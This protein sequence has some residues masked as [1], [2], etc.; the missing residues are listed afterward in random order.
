MFS[1][2]FL[3]L[4]ILACAGALFFGGACAVAA[5]YIVQD[6]GPPQDVKQRVQVIF[7]DATGQAY[8]KTLCVCQRRLT[9]EYLWSQRFSRTKMDICQPAIDFLKD[10]WRR[11]LILRKGY[12]H[13]PLPNPEH[14]VVKADI[15]VYDSRSFYSKPL[16]GFLQ[17]ALECFTEAEEVLHFK[18]VKLLEKT[19]IPKMRLNDADFEWNFVDPGF[20]TNSVPSGVARDTIEIFC[21]I[22][23]GDRTIWGRPK[24]RVFS[25][26]RANFDK[27]SA[28]A[29]DMHQLCLFWQEKNVPM[30]STCRYGSRRKT[31]IHK[32]GL[33]LCAPWFAAT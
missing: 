10:N 7:I 27:R 12:K 24:K 3:Q 18:N 5:T 1:T 31:L 29:D 33:G 13:K 16:C 4:R 28:Y 6:D 9:V 25:S 11:G 20:V 8:S 23:G 2:R 21:L 26:M 15:H 19:D 22:P 32:N 30:T 17:E 14:A